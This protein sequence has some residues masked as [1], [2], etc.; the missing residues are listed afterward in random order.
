MNLFKRTTA[1]VALIALVSSVFTTGVSA[2]SSDEI[3][4][5]SALATK[6]YIN[7]QANVSDYNLDMFISRAEISKVAANVAELSASASCEDKF[8]DVSATT[9]NNWVCGYVEALLANGFV[10]ANANYNPNANLTQ[11]EAVKLMLTV[12]GEEVSYDDA[13][14]QADFVS[15]AVE[16]GFVSNFS[17]YNT[18]ATRGFVFSVAAAATST[19][20]STEEEGDDILSE[21]DKL[22]GGD[23]EEEETMTEDD[24]T[25]VVSGN[26]ELEVTLSADTADSATVPG[27]VNGLPAASF[28]FTAGSED[29]IVTQ[30]T[31]KRT[32]LSDADTLLSLA[33]FTEEGRASNEK[34]DNQE[35]DTEAQMNLADGGVVVKAGET[36]TLTIVVDLNTATLA[37]QDEFALELVDVVASASVELDDVVANTIRIGSVDAPTLVFTPGSNVSNPTLGEEGADIFEFEVDG[38]SNE[39]VV[40]KSITFEGSNN[41]EDNLTN[42]KL[43]FNGDVVAETASMNDD[44]LTF[45]MEEG[46][47]IREDKNEDFLVTADI[48]EGAGDTVTFVIDEALDV[49]AESTKFGYGASVN[50]TA[51]D[52]TNDLGSIVIEAGELT[53]VEIE[54]D[55]DEIREDKNNVVLGGFQLTNVAGQNLELKEFGV[56][57]AFNAGS[58]GL[59]AATSFLDDVELYNEETGSSYELTTSDTDLD[60]V[61]SENS[62]DVVIPQGTTVWSIRA[63]TAEN[64]TAFDTASFVL[65]FTTGTISSTTGGFLVE[66]TEDDTVVTDITPSSISF[67]TVDGS[68]SGATASLVPLSDITVVRGADDLVVLQFEIE[69][70]ESSD[71]ILDEI[72][73]LITASPVFSSSNLPSTSISEAKLYLGSTSGE[74]LDQES[75]SNI[76]NDGTISFNDFDDVVIDANETQTFVVTLSFVDGVDAVNNSNYTTTLVSV[77]AEDDDNDD[78]AV[79]AGL[80]SA[81][82]VTVG[83]FGILTLTADANNEDNEDAKTIL[84]GESETVFSVD[85]QATNESMDVETVVFTVDTDLTSVI[86]NASLYLDD[87]LIDTNSNSDIATGTITFDDL[88]TLIV[89]EMTSELKLVLNTESIGYQKVG[90]TTTGINITNVALND[91]E[92]VSSGKDAANVTLAITTSSKDSAIVPAEVTP[93]VSTSLNSSATPQ[94]TFNTSVGDN[95][96]DASN[97]EANVLVSS[98]RLSNLGTSVVGT[99]VYTMTNVDDSSDTSIGAL[100]SGVITFN[101]AADLDAANRTISG[102]GNETFKVTITGTAEG[103][104]VALLLLEDGLTYDVSGTTG[105]TGI[106]INMADE[107]DLGSRSY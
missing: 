3:A 24:T 107:L 27:S 35:N 39:D 69:A 30:V 32:G 100:V 48:V 10:S 17:D 54:P 93:S 75:G 19:S 89:E 56:Q 101:L 102:N 92:G 16:N 33:V 88:D 77:S 104:T 82:D 81:R 45:N 14:W 57:I 12:A 72:V 25:T 71:V 34:N 87:T 58:T 21:L 96:I 9:P 84:A 51:V 97:S 5:A 91:V 61:F 42:F 2:A 22:L 105:S 37:G 95:S 20:T 65:S 103:D 106:T 7:T 41:S 52:S 46:I 47:T 44:Y 99:E 18:A 67:N 80:V 83:N 74:L 94:I 63:D 90:A 53:I 6:G 85:V 29:V 66:E 73:T 1:S 40:V 55:F 43:Y 68:E 59:S 78:I 60:A 62:I 28:D 70:E 13:T 11:A 76:A 86:T 23:D 50:I 15:Y 31:V 79:T 38:D 49:T 64:I 26:G 4:A 8:A 36:R 98:V